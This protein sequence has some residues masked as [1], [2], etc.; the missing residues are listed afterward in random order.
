MA[1][2]R[3]TK[4]QSRPEGWFVYEGQQAEKAIPSHPLIFLILNQQHGVFFVINIFKC[5]KFIQT[6]SDTDF[7]FPPCPFVFS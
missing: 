3:P 5:V 2:W 6:L 7:P 4:F 1:P